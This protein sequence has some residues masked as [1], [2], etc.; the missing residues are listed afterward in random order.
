MN[1]IKEFCAGDFRQQVLEYIKF[2]KIFE[3]WSF[4]LVNDKQAIFGKFRF[5][6]KILIK[7]GQG[8]DLVNQIKVA[9]NNNSK[10][11]YH[12][13]LDYLMSKVQVTKID[14]KKDVFA[15]LDC[16]EILPSFMLL[17]LVFS[18]IYIS[19]DRLNDMFKEIVDTM[20]ADEI[21][22]DTEDCVKSQKSSEENAGPES[23]SEGKKSAKAKTSLLLTNKDSF[24]QNQ[25]RLVYFKQL[26]ED[27]RST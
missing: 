7:M 16:E 15:Y 6:I 14:N 10:R 11:F 24:V 26:K 4:Y 12:L 18:G 8:D 17:Y 22:V 9:F 20:I 23:K 13:M 1:Q 3:S 19:L 5:L 21:A 2:N 25:K 27:M